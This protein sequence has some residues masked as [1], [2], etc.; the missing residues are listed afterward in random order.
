MDLIKETKK[1]MGFST[2][3]V[4]YY[5]DKKR[6]YAVFIENDSSLIVPSPFQPTHRHSDDNRKKWRGYCVTIEVAC[7]LSFNSQA[8]AW[9][10]TKQICHMFLYL[11]HYPSARYPSSATHKNKGN[12][13]EKIT[14][15][16]VY[17]YDKSRYVVRQRHDINALL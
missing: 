13:R 12:E 9:E 10:L 3:Q 16:A 17:V 5:G 14:T 6:E 1:L 8:H 4:P 2:C 11:Y 7:Q 15:L